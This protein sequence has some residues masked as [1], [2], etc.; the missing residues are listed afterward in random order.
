MFLRLDCIAGVTGKNTRVLHSTIR[1]YARNP[2]FL[3]QYIRS[4][5]GWDRYMQ[6]TKTTMFFL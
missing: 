5:W 6:I 2:V 4:S 3:L 1:Y